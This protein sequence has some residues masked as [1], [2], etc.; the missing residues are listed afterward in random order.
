MTTWD[1]LA[2][3]REALYMHASHT[4]RG[5]CTAWELVN[6]QPLILQVWGEQP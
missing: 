3:H 4:A 6:M 2:S 5:M 1:R